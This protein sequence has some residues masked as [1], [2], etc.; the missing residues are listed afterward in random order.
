MPDTRAGRGKQKSEKV[1]QNTGTTYFLGIGIDDYQAWPRLRNAVRDVRSVSDLL[2]SDYGLTREHTF[3]LFDEEATRTAIIELLEK[4]AQRVKPT[5]SLLVYY[6][7]H[8]HLNER[9]RGYWVPA[10]APRDGISHYIP[11]STI[12]DYLGD[13]PSLHTLLISD[14][15]FSGSLFVRGERS[16]DLAVDELAKLSSRWAI[17]S[18]RHDEVVADGPKDGHSPFAESI[19]D[20]LRHTERPHITANFLF[21]QVRDQTRANYDQL[22]DG[23][24]IQG[25]GHKRGQFIFRRTKTEAEVWMEVRKKGVA[26]AFRYYLSLF[27]AGTHQEEAEAELK[28]LAGDQAWQA[29][30]QMPTGQLSEVKTALQRIRQYCQSYPN[31]QHYSEA[32]AKG[33]ELEHKRSFFEVY[34]SEFGLMAFVQKD[35]PFKEEAQKRLSELQASSTTSTA[36]PTPPPEPEPT[37][38]TPPP[39]PGPQKP[40]PQTSKT[41]S[42]QQIPTPKTETGAKRNW[43]IG[44][45]L[46]VITLLLLV[47]GINKST[48]SN[49]D[50]TQLKNKAASIEQELYQ[51]MRDRDAEQV[52]N[53]AKAYRDL[54]DAVT[55]DLPLK[56]AEQWMSSYRDSLDKVQQEESKFRRPTGAPQQ[57]DNKVEEPQRTAA[58]PGSTENA[59]NKDDIFTLVDEV[60]RFPGCEDNGL[61][62][63]ALHRCAGLL[64]R[65]YITDKLVYPREARAAGLEGR[66]LIDL[67]LNEEGKVE[68][69]KIAQDIGKG[70]GAAALEVFSTMQQE[71]IRWIP[72]KIDGKPVKVR[73]YQSVVFEL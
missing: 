43:I 70:C 1:N 28:K 24:P 69:A 39:K 13:I 40:P 66:V 36:S 32:L 55:K 5:D 14:S 54:P 25:V 12:R 10:D 19:L 15:C 45:I 53:W 21:E 30:K 62:K 16:G 6:A 7:G 22:P 49:S 60:P 34:D 37:K 42:K 47:W 3:T 31:H 2:I 51:A 68:D 56:R 18:G 17:C 44:G 4:M 35:T 8:G 72:G 64:L 26:E 50:N 23:G 59:G 52:A 20:V 9:Q 67:V 58:R 11:N 46:G 73:L 48:G 27:P 63:N 71:G 57:E 29:L 65:K 38:P 41:S 33:Q 61:T